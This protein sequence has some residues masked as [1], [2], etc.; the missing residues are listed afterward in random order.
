[1][2]EDYAHARAD[3]TEALRIFP[4]V[5]WV[6]KRYAYTDKGEYDRA[7]A[8][9]NEALRLNSNDVEAYYNRGLAYAMKEDYARARTDWEKALQ[10]DPNHANARQS[11][12]LLRVMGY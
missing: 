6:N 1:M 5:A 10:L 3:Y 4:D 11:L 9:C 8:D 2:K 7:I 12:E